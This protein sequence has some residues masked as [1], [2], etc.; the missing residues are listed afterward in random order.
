MSAGEGVLPRPR[1]GAGG[2]GE[3]G[4]EALI[5]GIREGLLLRVLGG[6]LVWTG[7]ALGAVLVVAWLWAGEGGWRAGSPGPLILDLLLVASFL[8][9]A[10]WALRRIRN[11]LSEAGVA[12]ALERS[13]GLPEGAVYGSLELSRA[14]PG[15]VSPALARRGAWAVRTRLPD[16][17]REAVGELGREIRLWTLRGGALLLF[18][19]GTA[20]FQGFADGARASS[21]W[22]GLVAP[23]SVLAGTELPAL[24]IRPGPGELPRGTSLEVRVGAPGRDRVEVE[25]QFVGDVRRSREIEVAGGEASVEIGPLSAPVEFRAR[26]PDG[27]RTALVRIEPL[28][29]L[30]VTELTL[31]VR[32]PRHTGR[33]PERFR[34]GV[35]ELTLPVGSRISVEGRASTELETASLA[36]AEEE[37]AS[38]EGPVELRVDGDRFS[39]L[40]AP[41]RGGAYRW[42]FRDARGRRPESPPTPLELTLVP[43]STPSVELLFPGRDTVLP[44]DRRQPLVIRARDDYGLAALELVA[45]RAGALGERGEPVV[46]ELGAGGIRS[47]L[48]RP[49]LDVSGWEL[50]PGDSVVYRARAVDNGPRPDTAETREFV[51]RVPGS[52]EV[53]REVRERLEEAS[54]VVDSLRRDAGEA[55]EEARELERRSAERRGRSARGDEGGLRSRL[56]SL[57]PGERDPAQ[58]EG[59]LAYEEREE[60]RKAMERR[61]ELRERADSLREAVAELGREADE[62]GLTD[63]ELR[64]DLEELGELLRQASMDEERGALRE[65][66]ERV[67]SLDPED[68]SRAFRSLSEDHETFRD[69]LDEA[70]ERFR[71]TVT[72]QG[73]RSVAEEARELAREEEALAEELAGA[74]ESGEEP[75]RGAEAQEELRERTSELQERMDELE[76]RLQDLDEEGARSGVEEARESSRSA[77]SEMNRASRSAREGQRREASQAA[78]N[79]ASQ[80]Q[81]TADQLD[82]ARNEMA[83]RLDQAVEGTLRATATEAL[84]LARRQADLREAMQGS[85]RSELAELQGEEAALL[86]G[87]GSLTG[88]IAGIGAL[89]PGIGQSLAEAAGEAQEALARTLGALE[90]ERGASETP[91]TAAEEAVDALNRLA[92]A[93]SQGAGGG[94]SG[95][96]QGTTAGGDQ[97]R[98]RLREVARTQGS[99][100]EEGGELGSGELG[101]EAIEERLRQMARQQG[102]VAGELDELGQRQEE[103]E[104]EGEGADQLLG[105]LSELGEEARALA[106][107]LAE[108]RLDPE[109]RRRQERLFHRLLDAGRTL[110][111]D[112]ESRERES[113]TAEP[114]AAEDVTPLTE[115]ALGG[116]VIGIPDAELLR[117][118]PPMQRALILRYFE[119]LN[120]GGDEE[121]PGGGAEGSVGG[122]A[123]P[124]GGGRR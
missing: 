73:F 46:R 99:L 19:G 111:N 18:V 84:A 66:E 23:A 41:R 31:E 67:E 91:S 110:E 119:R 5:G 90:G 117:D 114:L 106:E 45:Y 24:E 88:R 32:Y 80:L 104:G 121:G 70:L 74:E 13:V 42:S 51:L 35:S 53:A 77:E 27:A 14:L 87:L 34:R 4:I 82:E 93:A 63:P 38:D 43:D 8:A 54:E 58:R 1:G 62:T 47:T 78:Q 86:Q 40:W 60:A 120:R 48:A 7:V 6:G 29:P 44:L 3:A 59:G 28:D 56:Q 113:R 26:A 95:A 79:A 101:P 124:G 75:R 21:A 103:G 10:G 72:E 115:E 108:G 123:S 102:A 76:E 92:L 81:E 65:L 50:T 2:E 100:L 64:E 118:L 89:A 37:G 33:A 68:L 71:R 15:G 20:A 39:G 25:W 17:A 109:T 49:R 57:A 116:S 94:A 83:Q 16:T 97:M 105:D 30:L 12:R 22:G 96:G 11:R 98:E 61:E 122:D 112:E 69:Q 52:A 55:A 85:G 36:R 9:G 107:R